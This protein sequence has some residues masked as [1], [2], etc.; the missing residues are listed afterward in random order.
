MDPPSKKTKEEPEFAY[1]WARH[2]WAKYFL[3]N[4][5][6]AKTSTPLAAVFSVGTNQKGEQ[7]IIRDGSCS[8]RKKRP[9]ASTYFH[10]M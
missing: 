5:V 9:M 6:V 8:S 7:K 4:K 3:E 1:D 2:N 10:Q